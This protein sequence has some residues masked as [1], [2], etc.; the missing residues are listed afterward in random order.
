MLV[1]A[2]SRRLTEP[3]APSPSAR[4]SRE[5]PSWLLVPAAGVVAVLLYFSLCAGKESTAATV[6]AFPAPP[7]KSPARHFKTVWSVKAPAQ[8]GQYFTDL[9]LVGGRAYF[10]SPHETGCL[11]AATGRPI[12]RRAAFDPGSQNWPRMAV[13]GDRLF[14][15]EAGLGNQ[16]F[17][18]QPARHR[19]RAFDT[20]TGRLLWEHSFSHPPW[21]V[22]AAGA[23]VVLV[24]AADGAV[25]GLSQSDGR[26]L[27]RRRFFLSPPSR[28]HG[29]TPLR[30]GFVNGLV[31]T[32]VG[33]RM[34]AF[35]PADGKPRWGYR[36]PGLS[37]RDA[38]IG[39]V[40][41]FA[42]RG[43]V[44]FSLLRG[45]LTAVDAGTGRCLWRRES[46][47][48][49][50]SANVRQA[51]DLVVC[52]PLGAPAA[53]RCGNGK[54]AWFT[55]R[56]A[57]YQHGALL[58]TRPGEVLFIEPMRR[59]DVRGPRELDSLP[60][61][62]TLVALDSRTGRERWH[63][64]PSNGAGIERLLPFG[65]GF[66]VYSQQE[67]RLVERGEPPELPSDPV[68]RHWLADQLFESVQTFGPLPG[69]DAARP[70]LRQVVEQLP[71]ARRFRPM[72]EQP[73]SIEANLGVLR[74]GA[75]AV[76][77][78]MA[79]LAAAAREDPSPPGAFGTAWRPGDYQ[80][81]RQQ[82]LRPLLNLLTDIRGRAAVPDLLPYLARGVD[83]G[84]RGPVAEALVRL[85]DRRAIPALLRYVQSTNDDS[86]G[87]R[88]ALY[89]VARSAPPRPPERRRDL[90]PEITAYLL[91]KVGHWRTPHW[92]RSFAQFE[93]L[94]NRGEAARK[95][96][97]SHFSTERRA[98][99]HLPRLNLRPVGGDRKSWADNTLGVTLGPL[100]RDARGTWWA[101]FRWHT[102]AQND[103]WLVRSRDLKRWSTPTLAYHVP[104]YG[105]T[106]MRLAHS[107]GR[108]LIAGTLAAGYPGGGGPLRVSIAP[109]ALN[110]DRDGDGLTDRI[111][112]RLGTDPARPD[113]NG[114]GLLDG[115]D[116]NPLSRPHRLTDEEGIYQA[117]LE[118]LCQFG[119]TA[120]Q[121][122]RY[123]PWPMSLG[124]DRTPVLI[125]LPA[126][127]RGVE[128][129][130]HPGMVLP[131]PGTP[132]PYYYYLSSHL[133]RF[134][135]ARLSLDGVLRPDPM[136][137]VGDPFAAPKPVAPAANP[138]REYFPYERRGDR[139]RVACGD[140]MW[141]GQEAV[142]VE[143]RKVDG[144][145][146]P[147]EC[148]R[149]SELGDRVIRGRPWG[150]W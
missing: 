135:R 83:E 94:N 116:K 124:R 56:S 64:Q 145:W 99:L 15:C 126:G 59:P 147:V 79:G 31:V 71:P 29:M 133:P 132:P 70:L 33:G 129:L 42:V 142:D 58:E 19:L 51:G 50:G 3:R 141:G 2:S 96:A 60:S 113:T 112:R 65:S 36:P 102:F 77:T 53:V 108:L 93:L 89:F 17:P 25:V 115:E 57:Q 22:M 143:V 130:G 20:V 104:D 35:T 140:P 137:S 121:Q 114:N 7:L 128:V 9:A 110:R 95:A 34:L 82:R 24:L 85:G 54:T 30:F 120:P 27:W 13:D 52:A 75:E 101:L 134:T 111:E 63:W 48:W 37:R 49:G 100:S 43:R 87:R 149:M 117:V 74:L 139:A 105:E 62:S 76:P 107:K 91:R 32:Q 138:F 41:E 8:H 67:V 18:A 73:D 122:Q 136:P 109:G 103:L 68:R 23:G 97:L 86:A 127:S 26:R 16:P 118:G 4:T 5:G 11:D 40:G 123:P 98:R 6:E 10:L 28:D 150:M 72:P 1:D 55:I 38:E 90:Q 131:Y 66:V 14:A 61:V 69:S 78:L 125:P 88:A 106:N 39:E 44:V 84:T 144:R 46:Q 148:R 47:S 81:Y 12:W 80:A 21:P 146:Y 119:R 92:F 45:H